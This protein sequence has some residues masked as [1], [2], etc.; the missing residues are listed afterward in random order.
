MKAWGEWDEGK[1]ISSSRVRCTLACPIP[2]F[3]SPFPHL[4]IPVTQ[5][6]VINVLKFD[7]SY[8]VQWIWSQTD[9][10]ATCFKLF[11][12]HHPNCSVTSSLAELLCL[13]FRNL[14][15]LLGGCIQRGGEGGR[16]QLP[17][18]FLLITLPFWHLPCRLG[19]TKRNKWSCHG[20][21]DKICPLYY[22]SMLTVSFKEG[23]RSS[24]LFWLWREVTTRN[25]PAFAG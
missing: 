12:L 13:F 4:L 17:F 3:T 18:L 8:K 6:N 9:L 22:I 25:M 20:G 23:R 5:V 10:F 11:R 7:H 1:L 14:H 16:G 2:P 19:F 21:E 24:W 15:C